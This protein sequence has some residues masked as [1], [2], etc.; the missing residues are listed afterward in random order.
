MRG[1]GVLAKKKPPQWWLGR[2]LAEDGGFEPPRGF[3]PNTLSK[4]AP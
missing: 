1:W 2:L 4:R 3:I